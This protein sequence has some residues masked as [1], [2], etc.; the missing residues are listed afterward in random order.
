MKKLTGLVVGAVLA[1]AIHAAAQ[2][3][4]TPTTR[5]SVQ[6]SGG[7]IT[8][9]AGHAALMGNGTAFSSG[10]VISVNGV[11]ITADRA[12]VEVNDAGGPRPD[13]IKLEGNVT[14]SLPKQPKP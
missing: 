10:V 5:Q 8:V 1:A 4:P 13:V 12:V 7:V 14:V 9:D 11:R 6:L 2:T 3:T